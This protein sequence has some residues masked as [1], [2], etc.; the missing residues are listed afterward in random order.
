MLKPTSNHPH[1]TLKLNEG[2]GKEGGRDQRLSAYQKIP[3]QSAGLPAIRMKESVR[4][5]SLLSFFQKLKK[6]YWKLYN[7][8]LHLAPRFHYKTF[9]RAST[10]RLLQLGRLPNDFLVTTARLLVCRRKSAENYDF[11]EIKRLETLGKTWNWLLTNQKVNFNC[12]LF[13]NF[14]YESF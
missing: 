3:E 14:L 1:S 8:T 7:F 13:F 11:S 5:N 9:N 4:R 12:V 2:A 6:T 10:N